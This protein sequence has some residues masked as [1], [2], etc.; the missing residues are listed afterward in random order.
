MYLRDTCVWLLSVIEEMSGQAFSWLEGVAI[1]PKNW[2]PL[3]LLINLF[4]S[5]IAFNQLRRLY[6]IVD[7]IESFSNAWM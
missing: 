2:I 5:Q 4:T 3:S 1:I 6:K 7:S